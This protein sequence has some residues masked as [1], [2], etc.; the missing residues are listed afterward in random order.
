MMAKVRSG[1]PTLALAGVGL[2]F[3]L[4]L[5]WLLLSAFDANA[6]WTLAWPT[7]TLGNFR[8][9]SNSSDLLALWNSLLLAVITAVVATV[10]SLFGA[11]ALARRRIPMRDEAMVGV[12]FL[13]A[14]PIAIVVI[15]M[16]EVLATLNWLSLAPAGLFLGITNMPFAL[17]LIRASIAAVPLELEEAAR[18]EQGSTVQIL[19]RVTLPLAMPG[20]IAAAFFSFSAGWSAFLVPLVVVSAAS[21]ATGPLALFG[22]IHAG[23]IQYGQIAAYSIL[24]SLPIVVLY[25][26]VSRSVSGGFAMGGAV[27]G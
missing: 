20:V 9:V 27:K 2:L 3:L 17:W 1:W 8:A 22:F 4:P 24:Y 12:L 11:Y 7:W 23:V 25:G 18:M 19:F 13:T 6:S 15:P 14:V 5:V 16:Y 26:A 10:P 21:Q